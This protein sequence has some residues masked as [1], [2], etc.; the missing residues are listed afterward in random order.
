MSLEQKA[1]AEQVEAMA[2]ELDGCC[3]RG[4][5]KETEQALRQEIA[6]RVRQLRERLDH[7]DRELLRQLE[8]TRGI[9][10]DER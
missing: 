6:G 4:E 7:T 3:R 10:G 2:E 9:E 1:E 5:A 8:E